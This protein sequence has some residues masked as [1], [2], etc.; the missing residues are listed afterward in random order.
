MNSL[1]EN[2]EKENTDI[3]ITNMIDTGGAIGLIN[4]YEKLINNQY[5][6][7]ILYVA[8]QGKILKNIKDVEI[9]FDNLEQN[10]STVYYKI[11]LCKF[12]IKYP[13]AQH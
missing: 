1:R 4:S 3:N 10:R 11:S 2:D 5:K 12:L 13:K 7:V 9:F 8:K 6:R